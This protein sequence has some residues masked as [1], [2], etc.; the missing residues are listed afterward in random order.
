[1]FWKRLSPLSSRGS[2]GRT[3]TTTL[4]PGGDKH[5]HTHTAVS[6]HGRRP[7]ARDSGQPQQCDWTGFVR[8]VVIG[9]IQAVL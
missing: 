6:T 9:V 1:M 2:G 7:L 3:R 8:R 4:K 5:T